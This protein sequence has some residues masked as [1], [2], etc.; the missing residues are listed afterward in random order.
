M[1]DLISDIIGIAPGSEFNSTVYAIAGVLI[2]FLVVAT[3]DL[4]SQFISIFTRIK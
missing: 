3:I 1:Y 4:I 2:I